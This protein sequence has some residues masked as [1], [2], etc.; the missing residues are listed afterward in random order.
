VFKNTEKI[1]MNDP[2]KLTTPIDWAEIEARM[3]MAA[4]K[5]KA[6]LMDTRAVLLADLR[7]LGITEVLGRYDGYGDNGN[8][9]YAGHRPATAEIDNALTQ[10]LEDFIWAMAYAQSPGFEN[11]DGGEGELTWNVESDK[12][13]I[14]HANFYTERDEYSWEDL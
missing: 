14:E 9:E 10:K 5:R 12:I 13:A 7:A 2:I 8:S 3:K 6:E 11:N 1:N 4:V